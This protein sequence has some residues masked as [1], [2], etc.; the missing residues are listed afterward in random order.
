MA[1]LNDSQRDTGFLL[2]DVIPGV[3]QTTRSTLIQFVI[4]NY[5]P[6]NWVFTSDLDCKESFYE[7]ISDSLIGVIVTEDED[8]FVPRK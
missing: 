4:M 8:F 7:F 3:W 1:V 6:W 2:D 5:P